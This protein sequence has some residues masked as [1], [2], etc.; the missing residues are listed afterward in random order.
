MSAGFK[1]TAARVITSNRHMAAVAIKGLNKQCKEICSLKDT[2]ETL[3]NRIVELES[4]CKSNVSQ[5]AAAQVMQT[6]SS[7]NSTP[8]TNKQVT[9]K[10]I[11]PP[12]PPQITPEKKFN[13][14]FY[15]TTESPVNTPRTNRQQHNLQ[16]ILSTLS[17]IDSSLTSSLI[18]DFHR[19]GKFSA[20]KPS[21]QPIL[22]KFLHTFQVEY[23]LSKRSL[24]EHPASIKPDMPRDEQASEA[25]FLKERWSLA[26]RGVDRKSIKLRNGHIYIDN[27]YL[28]W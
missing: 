14:I 17:I 13:L 1:H 7:V 9:D 5:P 20:S 10:S 22:V 2:V 15:G 25:A 6:Q 23:V 28:V 11:I 24:L 4:A 12:K 16:N 19:L 21:P 3:T 18:K 27:S 8:V 26:Q